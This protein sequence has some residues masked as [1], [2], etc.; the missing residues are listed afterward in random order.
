MLRLLAVL[1]AAGVL[2][3]VALLDRA[4]LVDRAAVPDP[5]A[6]V[7]A[8]AVVRRALDVRRSADPEPVFALA[9]A[10]LYSVLTLATRLV[11]GLRLDGRF[12]AAGLTVLLSQRL[13][14][15]GAGPWI[16]VSATLL[17]AEHGLRVGALEV[18]SVP[19]PPEA[20]VGVG[21]W[22]ADLVTGRPGLGDLVASL[23]DT[24]IGP[25]GL[26]TVLAMPV[27]GRKAVSEA[28]QRAMRTVA[29]SADVEAIDDILA[30]MGE[31]QRKGLLPREGSVLPYLRF[32]V[33]SATTRLDRLSPPVAAGSALIALGIACGER[34]LQTVTGTSVDAAAA[35]QFWACRRTTL[36]G[37]VDLRKHFTVSAALN[38]AAEIGAA[39]Q[40]GEFKE[41]YDSR[42]R[43]SG[44]SFD[45]L[46]A[47]RAGIAFARR[48]MEAQPVDWPRLLDAIETE[49]DLLPGIRDLPS[50]LS[51]AEFRARF[52]DVDS[53]AFAAMVAE[54][55]R[56]IAALPIH[57]AR[58]ARRGGG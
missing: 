32:A 40:I 56:R 57:A 39:V 4:P 50:G 44:F 19:L 16:N 27:D 9:P 22:L 11:P 46:A 12:E 37:R 15:G 49:S 6:A 13:P 26:T 3:A 53:P 42:P 48:L 47:N 51:E 14:F 17:P 2:A 34:H 31:A 18:G 41:L 29:V 35:D 1:A 25:G 20:T 52:G 23:R 10:E 24:R 43:G 54:I 55:D 38:A 7:Q 30:E 28:L 45:D 21:L 8:R 36:G 33:Q 58:L 5:A